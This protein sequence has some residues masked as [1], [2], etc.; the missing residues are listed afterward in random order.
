[1]ENGCEMD[2]FNIRLDSVRNWLFP[3]KTTGRGISIKWMQI[4]DIWKLNT[5]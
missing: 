2:K 3:N 4:E 1:M 5:K